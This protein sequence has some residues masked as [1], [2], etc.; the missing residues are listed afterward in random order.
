MNDPPP[1]PYV[2]IGQDTEKA[3][4][5][6]HCRGRAHRG[7]GGAS[8]LVADDTG[9]EKD[10][11]IDYEDLRPNIESPTWLSPLEPYDLGG[12][13]SI[14]PSINRY[15]RDF[16]R[17]GVRDWEAGRRVCRCVFCARTIHGISTARSR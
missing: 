10:K 13:A 7:G 8:A 5:N 4:K 6:G 2:W 1:P 17:E 12:G 11:E 9:Q 3:G 16:Q 14:N 15:L